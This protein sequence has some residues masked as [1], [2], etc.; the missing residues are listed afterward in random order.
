MSDD[1]APV[2][3]QIMDSE[4]RVA[5]PSEE[6]EA[7]L[8]AAHYLNDQMLEIR[9][10]GKV[11]GT[12]RIAVMAALNIVHDLLRDRQERNHQDQDLCGRIDNLTD[13]LDAT[14]NNTPQMEV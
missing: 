8:R 1:K 7:L 3:V 13:K 2:V 4:Y 14:L 10:G 6:H 9:A 12:E 5:C 11:L